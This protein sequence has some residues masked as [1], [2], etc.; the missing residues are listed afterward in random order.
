MQVPVL[1]DDPTML[2]LMVDVM[3]DWGVDSVFDMAGTSNLGLA[4]AESP[5]WD[6]FASV[7]HIG[8]GRVHAVCCWSRFN[9]DASRDQ[10]QGP[11][12]SRGRVWSVPA[13]DPGPADSLLMASPMLVLYN[14]SI[15]IAFI[16]TRRY[17]KRAAALERGEDHRR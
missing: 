17:E 3:T 16:V 11:D 7:R 9:S 4:D 8:P 6:S 10:R 15:L 2:D 1:S 12:P 5:S 13:V 14:L